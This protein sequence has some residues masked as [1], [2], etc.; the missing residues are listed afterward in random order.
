M[1]KTI[2]LLGFIGFSAIGFSQSTAA[3]NSSTTIT[4]ANN[5]LEDMAKLTPIKIGEK[6]QTTENGNVKYSKTYTPQYPVL[7]IDP[8]KQPIKNDTQI[9]ND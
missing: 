9:Q 7:M 5:A 8:E 3:N 1:K 2:I 4:L 6:I